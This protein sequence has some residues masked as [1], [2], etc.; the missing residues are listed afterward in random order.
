MGNFCWAKAYTNLRHYEA[1]HEQEEPR[2][3][4]RCHEDDEAGLQEGS[5]GTQQGWRPPQGQLRA[6][7]RD[8]LRGCVSSASISE[9]RMSEFALKHHPFLLDHWALWSRSWSCVQVS[10]KIKKSFAKKKKKKKKKKVL[11]V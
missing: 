9:A 5:P 2:Q 3:V 6:T 11:C 10:V 4:R 8:V 1:F 7:K